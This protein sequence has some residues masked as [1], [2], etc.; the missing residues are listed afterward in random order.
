[1]QYLYEGQQ[2]LGEIKCGQLTHRLLTGLS[3]D[4]TIARIALNS[5]GQKDAANSRIF[6]TDAL[7]SVIAQLSDDNAAPGSL[8]NS[9][10]YSPYGESTTVG[11][12]V[13]KNPVQYTSRENDGTGMMFYRA[14]YYDPV[15]KRFISSDPIGLGGGLNT[16]GYVLGDPVQLR[17]PTGN[18]AL[19]LGVGIAATCWGLY[20]FKT[21]AEKAVNS[22][23]AARQ[24]DQALQEWLAK[25]AKGDPPST[26]GELQD[27]RQKGIVD[28]S[29]AAADGAG[30]TPDPLQRTGGILKWLRK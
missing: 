4:E 13:T 18:N 6:M 26:Q 10:G 14:R 7:S 20:E 1:M 30:L 5:S 27:A 24:K 22:N 29:S 9:Y 17:D 23:A 8:Q 21:S 2:A 16:Y 15:M 25:G 3:L 11:P 12:D 19:M 28:T